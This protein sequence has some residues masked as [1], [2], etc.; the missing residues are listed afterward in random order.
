MQ[1]IHVLNF[2]NIRVDVY[3]RPDSRRRGAALIANP[4]F[5]KGGGGRL[6]ANAG[7][8]RLDHSLS[9]ALHCSP[10]APLGP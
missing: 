4:Q 3:G 10:M 5:A 1:L 2:D 6:C 8:L 7:G 9:Y